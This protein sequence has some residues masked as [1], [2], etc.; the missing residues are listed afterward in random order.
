MGRAWYEEH[1][2]GFGNK[3]QKEK[4]HQTGDVRA[5]GPK[6][7]PFEE[8]LSSQLSGFSLLEIVHEDSLIIDALKIGHG[9][10]QKRTGA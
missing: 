3:Y 5:P 10:W 9:V 8:S 6:Y 1:D 7:V 4:E 2:Y